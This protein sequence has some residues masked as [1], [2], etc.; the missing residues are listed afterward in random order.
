MLNNIKTLQKDRGFTIVELLIVIVVIAILAAITIVAYNGIQNQARTT[1]AKTNAAAVQK[2]AESLAAASSSEGGI[3]RYPTV[4]SEFTAST[5]SKLPSGV[6]LLTGTNT[7]A[8]ATAS[9]RETAVDYDYVGTASAPTGGRI[10]FWNFN[11]G[12]VDSTVIYFGD[13]TSGS[14]FVNMAS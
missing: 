13:A 11:T 6:T 4:T 7:L 12:A 3:G 5:I 14:T 9:A 8:A 10:Q 2:V 1:R